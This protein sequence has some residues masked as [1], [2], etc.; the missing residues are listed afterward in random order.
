MGKYGENITDMIYLILGTDRTKA[1]QEAHRL[2]RKLADE[3][4]AT[5]VLRFDGEGAIRDEIERLP[6]AQGLFEARLVVIMDRL[7]ANDEYH[8]WIIPL[9]EDL[10]SSSNM[11]VVIEEA[12]SRPLE[13]LETKAEKTY[14]FDVSLSK[15]DS[16]NIF[17]LSD[18]FGARDKKKLWVL[19]QKALRRHLSPEEI[20]GTLSWQSRMML[21]ASVGTS[22]EEVGQKPFVFSKATRYQKKYPNNTP[23]IAKSLV[24][25]FHEARRGR[26]DLDLAL[27]HFI[28]SL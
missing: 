28:L 4:R 13:L 12:L 8:S 17:E 5:H 22:A 16:F 10:A 14:R 21:G 19:Y 23:H 15:T 26:F 11:F 24:K 20:H 18:A 25:I 3:Y 2:S 6:L 7:G 9:V 1:L 27:E